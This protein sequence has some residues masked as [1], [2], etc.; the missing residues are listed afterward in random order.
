MQVSQQIRHPQFS[1]HF[2]CKELVWPFL[3]EN[4]KGKEQRGKEKKDEYNCVMSHQLN[5]LMISQINYISLVMKFS[6]L[7]FQGWQERPV[8][9]K[10]RYM[11]YAGCKRKF[12]VDG[13]ISYVQRIVGNTK[14]RK[15][16]NL[17]NQKAKIIQK[18]CTKQSTSRPANYRMSVKTVHCYI[19]ASTCAVVEI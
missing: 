5:H 14:K 8:F 15:G 12:D 6:G 7:Y 11:N 18:D 9:G 16:E 2:R 1:A 4:G 13:Y 10:I 17:L 3:E 19:M